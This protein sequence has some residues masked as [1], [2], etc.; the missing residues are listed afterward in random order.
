MSITV[1][2]QTAPVKG[3]LQKKSHERQRP[4]VAGNCTTLR[5][6]C[7]PVAGAGA[8]ADVATSFPTICE[9]APLSAP[10]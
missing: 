8:D 2:L 6:Y 4:L 7:A 3:A 5:V 1:T 10:L 9:S